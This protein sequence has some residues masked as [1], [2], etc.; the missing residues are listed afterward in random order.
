M[1]PS[2]SNSSTSN[3]LIISYKNKRIPFYSSWLYE[4][5]KNKDIRDCETGQLLIEA[6]DIKKI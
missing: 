1:K 4:R 2:I 3:I 5:S 6:S